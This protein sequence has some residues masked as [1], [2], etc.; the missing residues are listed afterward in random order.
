MVASLTFGGTSSGD[1]VTFG[2]P[3]TPDT[4]SLCGWYRP[5]T[6]TTGRRWWGRTDNA[7]YD[8]A[9]SWDPGGGSRISVTFDR[10]SGTA[11][12]LGNKAYTTN[13]WWCVIA[14]LTVGAAPKLYWGDAST[15]MAEDTYVSQAAGTSGS[16][17]DD[18]GQAWALGNEPIT[19]ASAFQGQLAL[20]ARYNRA[21]SLADVQR[22]RLT[23]FVDADLAGL[24]VC[25]S[26]TSL[27]LWGG[28]QGGSGSMTLVGVALSDLVPA[29][30]RFGVVGTDRRTRPRPFAPL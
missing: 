4:V 17:K 18:S 20:W 2:L 26:V 27:S 5:T 16:L 11:S 9:L 23:P 8:N 14:T 12:A 19:S 6:I 10:A 30:V 25:N 3:R 15:A 7:T 28:V 21:L 22:W 13:Q 29:G 1:R 24:V